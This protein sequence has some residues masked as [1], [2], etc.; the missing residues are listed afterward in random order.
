VEGAGIG[1]VVEDGIDAG[2]GIEVAGVV[3]GMRAEVCVGSGGCTIWG[4]QVWAF[5]SGCCV[6]SW[7]PFIDG[8]SL[9]TTS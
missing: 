2:D 5:R 4:V 3:T 9:P 7:F 8:V 1:D 6:N